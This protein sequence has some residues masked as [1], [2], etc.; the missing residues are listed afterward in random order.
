MDISECIDI[1]RRHNDWRRFGGDIKNAPLMV[2]P[3]K[4]GRAIDMAIRELEKVKANGD[5][6][7]NV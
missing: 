2:P 6:G 4:I 3:D 5:G 7:G 1:L